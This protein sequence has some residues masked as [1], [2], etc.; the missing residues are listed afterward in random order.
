MIPKIIHYCWFGGNPLSDLA[1]KCISSWKKYCPDYEIIEWNESNFNLD[2]CAYVKEAYEKK[3]WA[4]VTDYVR[5][6]VMVKYGGIYMD[7]DVEV[8]KPLDEFLTLHAFSGFE[9]NNMVPTGIMAC[10]QN[11]KFFNNLLG[12]YRNR[13]FIND[14]GICD[15][16][17]NVTVITNACVKQSLVMNNLLQTVNGFTLYPF[18]FFCAKDIMSGTIT[19]TENTYTIH[20]FAG[21]WHTKHEKKLIK[22][23]NWCIKHFGDYWGYRFGRVLNFPYRV[24]IKIEK[25]GLKN[26]WMFIIKKLLH[27]MEV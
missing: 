3:M 24:I 2:C 10:E 1:K 19:I 27:R 8:I 12:D 18:D 13:K 14:D 9:S 23:N 21:S 4:F 5:L 15:L 17:T 7:T 11:F 6:F 20:H 16:T 25:L 26:S 22:I